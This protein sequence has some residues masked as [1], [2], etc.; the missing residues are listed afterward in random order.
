[1]SDQNFIQTIQNSRSYPSSGLTVGDCFDPIFQ[2]LNSKSQRLCGLF[3]MFIIKGIGWVF[4]VII[5]LLSFNSVF[6]L[7]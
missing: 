2:Y 1:M 7:E 3:S 6:G 4:F 5:I